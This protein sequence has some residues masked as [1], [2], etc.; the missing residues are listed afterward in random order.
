MA[1]KK[2]YKKAVEDCLES[3]ERE[4][5]YRPAGKRTESMTFMEKRGDNGES[6][7]V[8]FWNDGTV[9]LSGGYGLYT[10][11]ELAMLII[12]ANTIAA[13]GRRRKAK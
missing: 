1:E 12:A 9:T 2:N 8:G 6:I 11:S 13:S 3:L 4:Y 7:A 5:G 10:T